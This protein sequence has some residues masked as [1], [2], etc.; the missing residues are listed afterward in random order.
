MCNFFFFF[1]F[2]SFLFFLFFSCFV[3]GVCT[4]KLAVERGEEQR[5]ERRREWAMTTTRRTTDRKADHSLTELRRRLS[6]ILFS[7][8]SGKTRVGSRLA[9]GGGSP[10]ES[11]CVSFFLLLLFCPG[12]RTLLFLRQRTS[13]FVMVVFT[14]GKLFSLLLS[15]YFLFP[16]WS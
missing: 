13:H 10:N 4:V 2:F 6:F 5:S 15:N 12:V 16:E 9:S 8:F 7:F 11:R 14:H 1:F 3:E